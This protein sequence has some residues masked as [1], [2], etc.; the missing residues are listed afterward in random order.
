MKYFTHLYETDL[1]VNTQLSQPSYTFSPAEPTTIKVYTEYKRPLY[2][3]DPLTSDTLTPLNDIEASSYTLSETLNPTGNQSVDPD[4]PLFYTQTIPFTASSPLPVNSDHPISDDYTV[5]QYAARRVLSSND[6][7]TYTPLIPKGFTLASFYQNDVLVAEIQNQLIPG[8]QINDRTTNPEMLG[9]GLLYAL[10][11]ENDELLG[12]QL[13]SVTETYTTLQKFPKQFTRYK[14]QVVD[15]EQSVYQ[16]AFLAFAVVRAIK[17]F[18]NRPPLIQLSLD[19]ITESLQSVLRHIAQLIETQLDWVSGY[20]YDPNLSYHTTLWASIAAGEILSLDYSYSLHEVAARLFLALKT[21]PPK[22]GTSQA[23]LEY[24]RYLWATLYQQ[25]YSPTYFFTHTTCEE[26]EALWWYTLVK[27]DPAYTEKA[28]ARY[29]TFFQGNAAGSSL[30]KDTLT[31]C[32]SSNQPLVLEPSFYLYANEAQV[33]TLYLYQWALEM[34]PSGRLWTSEQSNAIGIVGTL[35]KSIA[36]AGFGFALQ[37]FLLQE[38]N[39]VE[40]LQAGPLDN[41][42]RKPPLTSDFFWSQWLT[43]RLQIQKPDELAQHWGLLPFNLSEEQTGIFSADKM[44]PVDAP[45]TVDTPLVP[46]DTYHRYKYLRYWNTPVEYQKPNLAGEFQVERFDPNH[47]REIS[48]LFYQLRPLSLRE[49]EE[50]SRLAVYELK[51]IAGFP[52]QVDASSDF[53]VNGPVV[54]TVDSSVGTLPLA[55][56]SAQM[57]LTGH[58]VY[59]RIPQLT[60][61]GHQVFVRTLHTNQSAARHLKPQSA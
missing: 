45:L 33:F 18:R 23:T 59:H 13:K 7:L 22:D 37:F 1:S 14:L 15:S 41:Y 31:A 51:P 49:A 57:Q 32:L 29:T 46:F 9:Y 11:T 19:S 35:L 24:T 53:P 3:S 42:S 26:T 2:V 34:W 38:S 17:Y 21:E 50:Q 54:I 27:Q 36:A 47:P 56:F 44:I 58:P 20:V 28:D 52:Y 4:R 30:T 48:P 6:P 5:N 16:N 60:K 39:R 55:R 12:L 10:A 43:Q 25:P 8:Q 61:P 40:R